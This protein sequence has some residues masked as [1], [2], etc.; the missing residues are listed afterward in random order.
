MTQEDKYKIISNDY[1]DMLISNNP[2]SLKKYQDYSPHVMNENF[3]VIYMPLTE[4]TSSFVAL[5]GYSAIPHCYALT[6]KQSLEASGVSRLRNMPTVNLR[7]NG[8]IVGIIDTGIDY[9]NPVFQHA[10]GTSRILAIWDQSIDSVNES[11]N[12]IYPSFYG[13]EYSQK[14]I[15]QALKSANPLEIIPTMDEIGHGTKL[16]GIAAGSE[17]QEN[18]FSGV[19]PDADLL[20]VKLKQAKRLL[21]DYY[22]IPQNVPCYQENDIIWGIQYLVDKAR[23]LRRPISICIG[24]GTSLGAH[25]NTGFLNTIVSIAGDFPGVCIAIA[26]GN[27]SNLRRHFYSSIDPASEP[28]PVE[29]NVGENE[30]G[31]TMELWGDP[32]TIYSLDILSPFG[33]YIPRLSASLVHKQDI[34]FLF[35]ETI[36]HINYF[37]VETATGKEV[38]I[39]RFKNPTKGI[40]KLQVYGRGDLPGLFHIWLPSGNFITENTLFSNSNPYTTITSPGNSYVPITIVAYNANND[41]LYPNSGKGYSTSNIINPDLAAP[42]V[43]IQCPALDHSFTTM[44]GT[45]AAAAHTTGIAAMILEWSIVENNYPGIDTVGIKK[46]LIRGAKRS[47]QLQYPNRDWGYGIIDIYNSFNLL[48]TDYT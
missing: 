43:A 30:S 16:A 48:R 20:I 33:E 10:D 24:L 4:V 35:E 17:N 45:S 34:S 3:A 28:I 39:L 36:I 25:D 40:W 2:T 21:M 9:T 11:P 15:N 19:V 46:F 32:P 5:H 38:I 14:Q 41:A 6:N 1:L 22:S 42:G 37:L 8:V 31:F 12:T 18:D 7:G 23:S 44:T 29:L 27:E 13:T 47:D 26:A